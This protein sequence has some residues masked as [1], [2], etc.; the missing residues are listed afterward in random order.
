MQWKLS[1]REIHSLG[2]SLDRWLIVIKSTP[3]SANEEKMNQ[4]LDKK[5][6]SLKSVQVF[7][8]F[9]HIFLSFNSISNPFH[10]IICFQHFIAPF[11][12][13]LFVWNSLSLT[14]SL[15]LFFFPT[16]PPL[17]LS[18]ALT[19][20]IH[21]NLFHMYIFIDDAFTIHVVI[22]FIILH[23]HVLF[24]T[25]L[26][27]IHVLKFRFHFVMY[28]WVTRIYVPIIVHSL[29]TTISVLMSKQAIQS[30]RS[31]FRSYSFFNQVMCNMHGDMLLRSTSLSRLFS[32]SS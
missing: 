28:Q 19:V 1:I 25:L 11:T 15:S 20:H 8:I 7:L 4:T 21:T 23:A 31:L 30:G 18:L 3:L 29:N 17:S 13:S 10:Y 24:C 14:R 26:C 27:Y 16:P 32:V 6:H 22:V 12:I 5:M 9:I 2:P